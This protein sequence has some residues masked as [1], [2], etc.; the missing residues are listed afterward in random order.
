MHS[1]QGTY[2]CRH[3]RVLPLIFIIIDRFASCVGQFVLTASLR[4]QVNPQNR[5]EFKE[6]SP[7]RCVQ[8]PPLPAI[9][10][11]AFTEHSQT[12]RWDPLFCISLCTTSWVDLPL[13]AIYTVL[14][15]CD[16]HSARATFWEFWCY[17]L[18]R[19]GEH[20]TSRYKYD[21]H[22]SCYGGIKERLAKSSMFAL[23]GG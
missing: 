18:R 1:W 6:V 14:H 21:S 4:A 13:P 22:R 8:D 3:F 12:S 23:E 17:I 10:P 15:A 5:S 7:E 19:I 16:F 9:H 2:L 11:H 20:E